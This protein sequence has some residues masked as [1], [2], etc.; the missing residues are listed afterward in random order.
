M[1]LSNVLKDLVSS[2][3]NKIH[4]ALPARIVAVYGTDVDVNPLISVKQGSGFRKLPIIPSVPFVS[5]AYGGNGLFVKPM[6]GMDVLLLC[7]EVNID[8]YMETNNFCTSG[9]G[10][11]YSLTDAVCVAGFNNYITT[12]PVELRTEKGNVGIDELGNVVLNDGVDH[13]VSF[14]KLYTKLTIL[15]TE[16]KSAGIPTTVEFSDIKVEKVL[17]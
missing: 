10:R 13:A 8:N 3:I 2:Q 5:F 4:T 12:Y 7:T 1:N 9:D 11:S 6:V 15:T 17:L 14:E 16:L